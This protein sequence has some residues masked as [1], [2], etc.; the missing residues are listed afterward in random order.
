MAAGC[1]PSATWDAEYGC[2]PHHPADGATGT[3]GMNARAYRGKRREDVAALVQ[4][5]RDHVRVDM[6]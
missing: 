4:Q 5:W 3:E 1:A 2:Y 6:S